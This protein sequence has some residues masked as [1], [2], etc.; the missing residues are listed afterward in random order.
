[1]VAVRQKCVLWWSTLVIKGAMMQTHSTF[2]CSNMHPVPPSLQMLKFWHA[3]GSNLQLLDP[4]RNVCLKF[5][6]KHW[7]PRCVQLLFFFSPFVQKCYVVELFSV[8]LHLCL[9]PPLGLKRLPIT[10]GWHEQLISSLS[11]WVGG[12]YT[13]QGRSPA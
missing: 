7:I 4:K 2:K 11:C 8:C 13:S 10:L 9:P 5:P 3:H 6:Y 1:L 12:D